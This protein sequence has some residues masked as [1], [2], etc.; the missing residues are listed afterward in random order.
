MLLINKMTP[1]I[2]SLR[3]AIVLTVAVL[4]C[5]SLIPVMAG[6]SISKEHV[7]EIRNIEFTPKELTVAPGDTITWTNYDFV[8][9]TVTAD[10]E[11]WDS[12]LIEAEG[13]WQTVVKANMT[14]NYFCRYHPTMKAGL[15]IKQKQFVMNT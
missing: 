6:D 4:I 1:L 11:S 2:T 8:P 12:G 13:K 15:Q 14:T 10:D 3:N 7:V 5:S 9:H